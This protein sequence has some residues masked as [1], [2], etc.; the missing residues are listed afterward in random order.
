MKSVFMNRKKRSR[1]EIIASI[2]LSARQGATK[3]GIMYANYLSFSQLNKYLSFGL[4]SRII[5]LN[6]DARYFTTAKGLEYL[7]CFEQVHHIENDVLAKRK[8]LSEILESDQN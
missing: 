1:E 7:E 4:K 6:G 3:T 5:Y 8:T 2:L